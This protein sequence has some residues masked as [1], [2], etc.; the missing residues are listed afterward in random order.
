MSSHRLQTARPTEGLSTYAAQEMHLD[1]IRRGMDDIVAELWADSSVWEIV[2]A[3]R[4]RMSVTV[5]PREVYSAHLRTAREQTAAEILDTNQEAAQNGG[6]G[7][8]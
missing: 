8:V 7:T 1:S 2:D 5:T 3:I 4:E 6:D